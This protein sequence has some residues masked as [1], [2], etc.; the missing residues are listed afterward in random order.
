MQFT[1]VARVR[2]DIVPYK[3]L[4]CHQ[5]QPQDVCLVCWK[6]D[7]VDGKSDTNTD[8]EEDDENMTIK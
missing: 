7:A 5:M 1:A 2:L 3:N 8:D 6:L 4:H